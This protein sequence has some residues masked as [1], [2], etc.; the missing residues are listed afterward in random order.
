MF[1]FTNS[2]WLG[3]FPA[4]AVRRVKRP[5]L[6]SQKTHLFLAAAFTFTPAAVGHSAKGNH[7]VLGVPDH[8]LANPPACQRPSVWLGLKPKKSVPQQVL[9]PAPRTFLKPF[10]TGLDPDCTS[11]HVNRYHRPDV[12]QSQ[13]ETFENVMQAHSKGVKLVS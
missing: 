12:G 5:H 10:H 11:G 7:S 6:I 3:C 13:C 8:D 2:V 4:T 9:P 1:F